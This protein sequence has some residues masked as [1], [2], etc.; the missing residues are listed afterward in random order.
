[1]NE[2]KYMD[3]EEFVN[4]GYLQELNRLVLHPCGLALEVTIDENENYKL[5]GVWDY[6]DDPEG[7][8][9]DIKNRDKETVEQMRKK[10]DN[11]EKEEY[12]HYE[13][14]L[15]MFNFSS[16]VEPLG[17]EDFVRVK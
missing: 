10:R 15:K 9:F 6:R 2:R 11:V 12:N 16:N 7:I 13:N 8:Y 3:I 5:S 4:E 17:D 1:M 14:R